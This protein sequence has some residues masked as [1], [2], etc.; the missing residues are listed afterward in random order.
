MQQQKKVKEFL[1]RRQK[2]E[3]EIPARQ[4]H[5]VFHVFEM[6]LCDDFCVS[7]IAFWVSKGCSCSSKCSGNIFIS[8]F[9]GRKGKRKLT[10]CIE[11]NQQSWGEVRGRTHFVT[12]LCRPQLNPTNFLLILPTVTTCLSMVV[13]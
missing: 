4:R 8:N 3:E 11:G 7:S 2:P 10:R 12:I 5:N 9:N 13:N 6:L 1:E